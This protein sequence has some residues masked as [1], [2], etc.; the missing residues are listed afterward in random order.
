MPAAGV[1]TNLH[2]GAF[3]SPGA[4]AAGPWNPREIRDRELTAKV[5][6][7]RHQVSDT[8]ARAL[9]RWMKGQVGRGPEDVKVYL[10]DD[11]ILVRL[12]KCLT[13]GEAQVATS[14]DGRHAVGEF[15]KTLIRMWQPRLERLVYETLGAQAIRLYVD[16]DTTADELILIMVLDGKISDAVRK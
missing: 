8:I 9:T 13:P 10:V 4:R 2:S 1:S 11:M 6:R 16:L 7:L 14:G 3:A 5:D 15:R 12:A